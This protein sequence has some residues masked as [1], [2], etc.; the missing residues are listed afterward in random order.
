M[1]FNRDSVGRVI[2]TYRLKKR[3]S[4]EV[5][6]GLAGIPR[7]HLTAIENG[8]K[9]PNLE[10]IWKLCIALDIAPHEAVSA[11]E[12]DAAMHYDPSK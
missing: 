8:R 7:S 10:T 2:K 9:L 6:S 3:L 4:Q 11:M 5:L 12:E 1:N